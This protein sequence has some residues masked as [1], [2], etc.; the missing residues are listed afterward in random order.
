MSEAKRLPKNDY[1]KT[2]PASV[3]LAGL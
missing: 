1:P 2:K 3:N